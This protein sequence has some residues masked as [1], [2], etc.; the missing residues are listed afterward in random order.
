MSGDDIIIGSDTESSKH[1]YV[2]VK[3][4]EVIQDD[5]RT[6]KPCTRERLFGLVSCAEIP[7]L[8]LIRNNVTLCRN[9]I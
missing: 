6:I 2:A 4:S 3:L 1:R 5:R 8:I 9:N 7:Q